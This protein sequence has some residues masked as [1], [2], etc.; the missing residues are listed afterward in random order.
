MR[1]LH[2]PFGGGSFAAS[3]QAWLHPASIFAA[4]CPSVSFE[5]LQ[6]VRNSAMFSDNAVAFMEIPPAGII[7]VA[8][9]PSQIIRVWLLFFYRIR[10]SVR[11]R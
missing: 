10:H 6:T 3:V 7:P 1:R 8:F 2:A 11:V 5:T 4:R 9:S